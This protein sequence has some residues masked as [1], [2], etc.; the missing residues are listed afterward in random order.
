MAQFNPQLPSQNDPNWLGWSKSITQPDGDKS[1]GLAI[2]TAAE[3]LGEG[4]KLADTSFK[5]IIEDDIYNKAK[6][7]Q[8]DYLAKLKDADTALRAA[9]IKT[10]GPGGA[11][12]PGIPS[13][14]GYVTAGTILSTNTSATPETPAALRNLSYDADALGNARLNGKLSETDYAM[15][16]DTMAK[17]F[18]ARYPGYKEFIDQ[19]F[20][21]VT[22]IDPANK[23]ITSALGDVNSFLTG[24]NKEKNDALTFLKRDDVAAADGSG[25]ARMAAQKLMRGEWTPAQAVDVGMELLQQ[26]GR[27][28]QLQRAA[29]DA[30]NFKE[31]QGDYIRRAATDQ[32]ES[33][34]S[35]NIKAITVDGPGGIQPFT[36]IMRKYAPGSG[37]TIPQEEWGKYAQVVRANEVATRAK[38]N[39]DYNAPIYEGQPGMPKQS[40]AQIMGQPWVNEQ[41]E[42]KMTWH[43]N[44][45]GAIEK[46]HTGLMYSTV[47]QNQAMVTGATNQMYKRI[48][49]TLVVAAAHAAGGPNWIS[50]VV[51]QGLKNSRAMPLFD[52][53]KWESV[54]MQA[55]AQPGFKDLIQPG[56]IGGRPYTM[57]EAFDAIK[58]D[59]NDPRTTPPSNAL[60]KAIIDIPKEISNPAIDEKGRIGLIQFTFS[61][62]NK[63]FINRIDPD[64]ATRDGRPIA[65]KVHAFTTATSLEN[66]K[67]VKETD[68][69]NPELNLWKNAGNWITQ[70]YAQ[71]VVHRDI[72]N[73]NRLSTQDVAS[74]IRITWSNEHHQFVMDPIK[75]PT[76][77]T[78][79]DRNYLIV[80]QP[81]TNPEIYKE[82]Q[83]TVNRINDATRSLANYYVLDGKDPNANIVRLLKGIGANQGI[84]GMMVDAI[85]TTGKGEAKVIPELPTPPVMPAPRKD[86]TDT[87]LNERTD[88]PVAGKPWTE[89]QYKL[90]TD[91]WTGKN[92]G[93]SKI[94]DKYPNS[95]RKEMYE[96]FQE[97]QKNGKLNYDVEDAPSSG[98][99][100]SL[101]SFLSN[102]DGVVPY[103]QNNAPAG[104]RTPSRGTPAA[105]RGPAQR[106]NLTDQNIV[107]VGAPE[108]VPEG[109][110]IAE[111]LRRTR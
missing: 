105:V 82:A 107:G 61:P 25:R 53:Q 3:G 111:Y 36:E 64:G 15:R 63:G 23:A 43:K 104:L 47:M 5:S 39:E 94:L 58:P 99:V 109:M 26:K 49:A 42:A 41:I 28:V 6:A 73:L 78:P 89:D 37:L 68:A 83:A 38:L 65:G 14:L 44:V 98:S 48:P 101:G 93:A 30:K 8:S 21:K 62:E 71:E 4:L 31:V 45:L 76:S 35:N 106:V 88:I 46:E 92:P 59:P 9:Q 70:T 87:I 24:G 95:I 110:S 33:T 67:A 52:A 97:D 27:S 12:G 102:P 60:K 20:Q 29:D 10:S 72:A 103:R 100:G 19:T 18:R 66:L 22:G 79:S 75:M 51:T 96:R 80:N 32:A 56:Y 55:A 108:D 86:T 54:I 50:E 2:S 34:V 85:I 77:I 11:S 57:N 81:Q 84:P 40:A 7:E 69:R 91:Y 90:Y 16:L 74:Q 17:D 1:T 13:G